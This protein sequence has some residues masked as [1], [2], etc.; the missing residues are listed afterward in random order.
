MEYRSGSLVGLAQAKD[1]GCAIEISLPTKEHENHSQLFHLARALKAVELKRGNPME[2]AEKRQAVFEWLD[3]SRPFLNIDM[4]D[5]D[6]WFE[7]LEADE[8]ARHPLGV[9]VVKLAW[10][11]SGKSV[12]PEAKQFQTPEIQRLVSLC[13]EL[14]VLQCGK[15]FFLSCRTVQRLFGLRTHNLG[16][17][18]LAGLKRSKILD[19]A[20]P[21]STTTMRAT[22]YRYLNAQQ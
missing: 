10:E 9:D 14:A 11:R 22:R 21:G 18:W 19:I 17:R 1:L 12:P 15:P 5:D 7:F 4:S 2:L 20:E 16:A 8:N 6:Y 13:R 3:K